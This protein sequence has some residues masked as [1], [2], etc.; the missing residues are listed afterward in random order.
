MVIASSPCLAVVPPVEVFEE[1]ELE[2]FDGAARPTT[3]DEAGFELADRRLA[4]GK[5]VAVPAGSD[6]AQCSCGR[7]CFCL[8]D[9]QVLAAALGVV[10]QLVKPVVPAGP[11][12]HL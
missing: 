12:G 6:R 4:Q 9:G 10:H 11:D 2:L 1:G 8:S 3:V 7:K 5:V